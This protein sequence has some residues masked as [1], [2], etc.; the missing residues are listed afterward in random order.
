M[1][2]SASTA[3]ATAASVG[4]GYPTL[5]PGIDELRSEIE[6][7]N[8][9]SHVIDLET[10][11]YT[12]LPGVLAGSLVEHLAHSLLE[13]SAADREMPADPVTGES[14]RD[15]TQEIVL[16]ASRG[17]PA[18][19]HLVE[20]EPVVTLMTYLLGGSRRL[21]SLTGYIKGP[22]SCA[23]SVHSDTAYVPDPLP[24]YAQLANVNYTLTDY[25]VAD[26]C[27]Y[28]VPGSH[29]YCH[30]PREGQGLREIVP[31]IAPAGSAIVFH[32]NTWHGA[33]PRQKR[34]LRLTLSALYSRLYMRPQEDYSRTFSEAEAQHVSSRLRELLGLDLPTGWASKAEADL[35][36][37]RRKANGPSLYRTRVPHALSSIGASTPSEGIWVWEESG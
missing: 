33:Y 31:V 18:F 24:A 6:R 30:R 11:G 3:S 26:G 15:E 37:A 2:D 20:F 25:T 12:V 9:A 28:M 1:A 34:G 17:G 35:M 21:S 7:L 16:L 19:M 10:L 36:M 8:L 14:H 4:S 23:L 32:G 27:M 22:G 29:K 13:L 5:T